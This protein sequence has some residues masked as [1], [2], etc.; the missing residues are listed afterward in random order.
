NVTVAY[1]EEGD[2]LSFKTEVNNT[3]A[4]ALVSVPITLT[5]LV[6]PSTPKGTTLEAGMFGFGF[7]GDLVPLDRAELHADPAT[8]APIIQIDFGSGALNFCSNDI[9]VP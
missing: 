1:S 8:V 5:Y 9:D 2:R 4:N 7:R 6:F 3:S